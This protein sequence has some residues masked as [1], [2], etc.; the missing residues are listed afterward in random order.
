MAIFSAAIANIK[1]TQTQERCQLV[2]DPPRIG[3]CF[4]YPQ[5]NMFSGT[6]RLKAQNL[7][8]LKVF[9]AATD[10]CLAKG[11][12]IGSVEFKGIGAIH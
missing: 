12:T 5:V 9:N 11:W 4:C 10:L 2:S 3:A 6:A 7:F 1:M 8:N